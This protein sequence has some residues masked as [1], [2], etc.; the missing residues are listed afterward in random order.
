MSIASELSKLVQIFKNW[1]PSPTPDPYILPPATT[2][3]LGGVKVGD[4]LEVTEDGTLSATV[5]NDAVRV[6]LNAAI[7]YTDDEPTPE[8]TN[9]SMTA[10][11]ILAAYEA[12]KTVLGTLC[13]TCTVSWGTR[14]K[15]F[16]NGC[17][18]VYPEDEE[19]VFY[20]HDFFIYPDPST[21]SPDVAIDE[22][23]VGYADGEWGAGY[24][25]STIVSAKEQPG[26][27]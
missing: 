24:S 7:D 23:V 26:P 27:Q 2:N 5:T 12:G 21:S 6:V 14:E 20:F 22:F 11:E 4:G 8:V 1:A 15:T 3:T 19:V 9:V 10:E 17:F 16:N 13:L 18:E 25:T